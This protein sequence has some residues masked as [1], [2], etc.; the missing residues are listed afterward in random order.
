MEAPNRP[1]G[2]P[3]SALLRRWAVPLGIALLCIALSLGG[4]I[5]REL[6]RYERVALAEGEVWRLVAAHLVHLG[7][8]HVALNLAA[9]GILV[10]LFDGVLDGTAWAASAGASALAIDAGLYWLA[11]DVDWYVGLSG[12]LHGI[13]AAGSIGLIAARA[14]SGYALLLLV[15]AKLAWE[16]WAGPLPHSELMSGGPVVVAAHLYGAAGGAVAFVLLAM[17]RRHR[18]PPV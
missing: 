1:A 6:G 7:A 15:T 10:L 12:V 16:Q 2:F 5:A 18:S 9:L 13:V 8:G 17:V 11:P 14:P 4:D 3:R